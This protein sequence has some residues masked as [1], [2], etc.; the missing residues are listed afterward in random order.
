MLSSF[1]STKKEHVEKLKK[2]QCRAV[3]VAVA[4]AVKQIR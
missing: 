1:S 2:K 4:V 3:A